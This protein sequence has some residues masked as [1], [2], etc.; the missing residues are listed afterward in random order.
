[1]ASNKSS[2]RRGEKTAKLSSFT[3][4]LIGL[5]KGFVG[6]YSGSISLIAQAVDSLTHI[7]TSLAVY[8]GLRFARRQPTEKFPYGYYRAETFASLIVAI[9]IIISGIE[10][11]RE[12]I[13]R[14]LHPT[15]VS[16]PYL[17]LSV[18][19]ISIPLLYFLAKYNKKIGEEINSQ[20]IVGQA[21]DFALDVFSSVLVLVGVLFSYLDVLWI[22]PIMGV[23][24]SVLMLKTGVEI[25]RDS[26]LILMDAVLK[27]EDINKMRRIAEEIPGVL[28][29]HDIKLRKSGPFCF[30]EMHIEVEKGLSVEKAYTITEEIEQKTK[31]EFKELETLM[32]HLGPTKKEKFR[33]AIPIEEDK[34][35]E[36]KPT[37]HFGSVPFFMLIDIDQGK[38][39][40]WIIKPNPGAKLSKKRGI[41]AADFLIKEKV[42]MLLAGDLGAGPFHMLRDSFVEICKLSIDSGIRETIEA[43]LDDKLEKVVSPKKET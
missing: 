26:V 19:A 2:L 13:L 33:I 24:I 43:V 17:T 34:G 25:G 35:L 23:L 41:T 31:Q 36:S 30:G 29:V 11:I 3:I 12:S 4:A 38:T 6:A 42:N 7:F 32:I 37:P 18:A 10:I 22:E 8:V 15:V 16:S 9:F 40:N 39:K 5:A 21:K 27:P 20:A 1:M 28:G 14:F